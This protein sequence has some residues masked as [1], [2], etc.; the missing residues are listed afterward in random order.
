[1]TRTAADIF[2]AIGSAAAPLTLARAAD[3]FLPL[4]LADLARTSD[5]RLVYVATDDAAMQAVA[6][7]A[8]FFAPD[9]IVHRFPAWDCLPYDRAGP[10]LRISADRLATLS[11]LPAPAKRG[12]LI[13]THVAALPQR[14]LP[15]FRTRQLATALGAGTRIDGDALSEVHVGHGLIRVDTDATQ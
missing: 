12:E 6:D 9:L 3:G 1:M 2:A 13:L 7:A 10:S 15:P 11:A 14:T 8:P 4:L 5:R